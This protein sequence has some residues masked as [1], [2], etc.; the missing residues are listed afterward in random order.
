MWIPDQKNTFRSLFFYCL[1][2]LV[3]E[4]I[5]R[6]IRVVMVDR[7]PKQMAEIQAEIS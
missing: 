3:P 7:D 6:R 1:S 5:L 4:Y 2:N